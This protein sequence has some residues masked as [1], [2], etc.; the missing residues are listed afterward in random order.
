MAAVYCA[1][2]GRGVLASYFVA[3][4]VVPLYCATFLHGTEAHSELEKTGGPKRSRET[5]PSTIDSMC[6]SSTC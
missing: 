6:N 2:T 5:L 1:R 4:S 3:V